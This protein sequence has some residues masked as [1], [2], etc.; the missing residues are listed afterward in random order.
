MF[1][2]PRTVGQEP[3]LVTPRMPARALDLY[4]GQLGTG[5]RDSIR[6]LGLISGDIPDL[7]V[8]DRW[9]LLMYGFVSNR[10]VFPWWLRPKTLRSVAPSSA[11]HRRSARCQHSLLPVSTVW[12]PLVW[13]SDVSFPHLPSFSY[14][15]AICQPF[16]SHLSAICQPFVSVSPRLTLQCSRFLPGCGLQMTVGLE[17]RRRRTQELDASGGAIGVKNTGL[18]TSL[19]ISHFCPDISTSWMF[20]EE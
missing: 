10:T 14:L 1:G 7:A 8:Y 3:H 5:K 4:L 13:N 15:S 11:D 19:F 2:F 9:M 12:G 18:E 16:V 6:F 17:W 20:K